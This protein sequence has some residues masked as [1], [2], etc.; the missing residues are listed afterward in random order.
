MRTTLRI[1]DR[2]LREARRIAAESGATLASV[3]EDLLREALARRRL[4]GKARAVRLP[5]YNGGGLRSGVD[6]DDGRG[7]RDLMDGA[8]ALG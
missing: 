5:T 8:R 7:L 3:I 4:R 6:L 1:D 2:I